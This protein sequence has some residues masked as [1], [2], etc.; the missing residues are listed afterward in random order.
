MNQSAPQITIA[1]LFSH[2]GKKWDRT[3]LPLGTLYIAAALEKAGLGINFRDYQT[4]NLGRNPYDVKQI[5][6]FLSD[7]SPILGVRGFG[8]SAR[9]DASLRVSFAASFPRAS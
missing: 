8:L 7:G 2:M 4:W 3:F 9:R 1:N 5:A 6:A